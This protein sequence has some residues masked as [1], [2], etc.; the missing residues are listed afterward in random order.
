MHLP[1]F[2][3]GERTFQLVTQVAGRTGRGD[4]GGRVLV[5]TFSPD[6]PSILA[7]V[8]HDYERFAAAELQVREQYGYP[9][10][11]SVVRLVFRGEAE[12]PTQQ[13]AEAVGER[14]EATLATSATSARVLGPVAA[15]IAKLRNKYRFHM[16]LQTQKLPAVRAAIRAAQ[17]AVKPPAGVQWVIDIDAISML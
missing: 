8:E 10:L 13:F 17:A 4:K 5:Q 14:I 1:D 7:A 12:L 11:A 16:L 15:P 3:A 2:R 6:H 9:P